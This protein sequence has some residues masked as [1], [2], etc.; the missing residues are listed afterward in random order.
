MSTEEEN[1]AALG[2][3]NYILM[4]VGVLIVVVGFVLMSGGGSEDPTEFNEEELFHPIRITVAPITV[5][6]GYVIVIFAIMKR[7]KS[8]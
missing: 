3:L 7:P 6:V 2:K 5:V 1:K 8:K 4:A